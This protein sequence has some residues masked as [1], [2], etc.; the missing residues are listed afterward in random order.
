[1]SVPVPDLADPRAPY[2]QIAEHLRSQITGGHYQPGDRLP[3]LPVMTGEYKVS[4]ETV[5]RAL[6]E[7]RDEGLVATQATRGTFV[8]K[9]E[10]D[11]QADPVLARLESEIRDTDARLTRRSDEQAAEIARLREELEYTQAQVMALSGGTAEARP[12]DKDVGA[13]SPR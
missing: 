8:L 2:L 4:S 10:P 9:A 6:R 13:W 1:V 12:P 5:R 3:S 7:L 11:R